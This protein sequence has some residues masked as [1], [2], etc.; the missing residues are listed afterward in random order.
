ME[1]VNQNANETAQ[2]NIEGSEGT[3]FDLLLL[4][5]EI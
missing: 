1:D 2:R 3:K 4:A 5:K